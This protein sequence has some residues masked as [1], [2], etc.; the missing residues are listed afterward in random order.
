MML[1]RQQIGTVY[2]LTRTSVRLCNTGSRGS[3]T[4]NEGENTDQGK[5]SSETKLVL[6]TQFFEHVSQKDKQTYIEMVRIFESKSVHRRNH[7]EFIYAALKHMEEFGVQKD[8]EVYKAL[9]N[10]MPKG[11]FIPTNI[12]QA[13]FMH[14]PRQQQVIIDL[15]EQMEDNGVI[16]D[17]EME[18]ML[19]NVF[20]KKG[21]PVRKYWRMMYWMPKFKNLSPWPLP[22]PV[23]D[24]SLELAK[25]AVER[26][27]SVDLKSQISLFD[28]AE[29][30]DALD[31]TWIVS[32][33]SSEQSELLARHSHK[34]VFIEGPF[35]IWL[36]NRSI[37]Y[38]LLKS[39]SNPPPPK[40]DED[41]DD[42][43]KISLPFLGI[44]MTHAATP[45]S[46]IALKRS[47]HEQED[48]TIFAIC[49]TGT[50]TKDSLLSWVRLLEK[51][52]NPCLEHLPVLFKFSS[53]VPDQLLTVSC[54]KGSSEN[55]Q[56]QQDN[57]KLGS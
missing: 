13:E 18:S 1:I 54:G 28:T 40:N 35:L 10:V 23:P 31:Q 5:K 2:R 33:Q 14:Y 11:K 41:S 8:L 26:M 34:P 56:S 48:G 3:R 52:G 55:D 6:R 39:E 25:L 12:F 49:C 9:I 30:S 36:R 44:G 57:S 46:K 22:N 27:C 50:S 53:P 42:V 17:Y 43:R 19:I 24:E 20:G 38:Y 37:N 15:L 7:V 4:E 45:A 16:P 29:V 32:G 21:H 51:H 47:I